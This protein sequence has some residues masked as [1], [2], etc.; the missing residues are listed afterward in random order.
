MWS[1]SKALRIPLDPSVEKLTDIPYT[2]SFVIKKRLQ[3]DS[4]NE[5]EKN[6]RPPDSIVWDG[7]SEDL[8]NWL[9]SVFNRKEKSD[10]EFDF[11]KLD[12]EG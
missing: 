3:I 6:K 5:L 7:T 4:L 8:D 9:D 1:V 2:H 11:D 10:L 12:I